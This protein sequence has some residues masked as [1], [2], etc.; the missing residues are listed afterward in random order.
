MFDTHESRVSADEVRTCELETT[1]RLCAFAMFYFDEP[2][3]SK[4][5]EKGFSNL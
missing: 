1:V 3:G 2:D 5:K 4:K